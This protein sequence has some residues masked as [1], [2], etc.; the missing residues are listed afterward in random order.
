MKDKLRFIWSRIRNILNFRLV[1]MIFTIIGICIVYVLKFID[2]ISV[3]ELLIYDALLLCIQL[4]IQQ[5][6]D[7]RS[8]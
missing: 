4:I 2:I 7:R 8:V 3:V 6:F 5:I 1:V